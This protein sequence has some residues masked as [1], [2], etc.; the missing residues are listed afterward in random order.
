LEPGEGFR[1]LPGECELYP[2]RTP[3][4]PLLF[5][6]LKEGQQKGWRGARGREREERKRIAKHF[7]LIQVKKLISMSIQTVCHVQGGGGNKFFLY[8]CYIL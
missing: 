3:A 6:R 2:G 7:V 1:H 4:D 8:M 5:C